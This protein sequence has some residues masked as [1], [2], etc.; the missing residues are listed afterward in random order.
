MKT[1]TGKQTPAESSRI[2]R[3][4]AEIGCICCRLLRLDT[5]THLEIQHI[6]QGNKRLNHWYTICLCWMHHQ[7]RSIAGLWT[8]IAQGSKA[9]TE[10][11]GSQW[12]LWLKTQHMLELDDTLPPT[13]IVARTLA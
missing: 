2:E 3:M 9:F 11:H 6:L 5:T 7:N 13:K 10:V 12:D 4:K 8:S 1:S